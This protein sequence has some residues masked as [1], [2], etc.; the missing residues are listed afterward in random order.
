MKNKKGIISRTLY[1]PAI[2]LKL[3]KGGYEIFFPDFEN[4][5]TFERN[6]ADGMYMA[7]DYI[8]AVLHDDILKG[9]ELKKPSDPSGINIE[10]F[11]KE[12]DPRA[13]VTVTETSKV[14]GEGFNQ[15]H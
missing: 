2:F 8:G 1:Y 11:L 13:F 7:S 4:S 10:K 14:F 5:A 15:L 6:L 9:N 12:N 3:K